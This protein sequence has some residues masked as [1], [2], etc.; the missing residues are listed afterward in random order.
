[1]VLSLDLHYMGRDLLA[2]ENVHMTLARQLRV[3]Y[4]ASVHGRKHL[5]GNLKEL[6]ICE[7]SNLIS[8]F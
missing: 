8:S 2:Q 7:V 6:G 5:K 3:S 4:P 1:M